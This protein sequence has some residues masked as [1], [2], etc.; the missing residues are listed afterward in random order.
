VP[1]WLWVKDGRTTP[2]VRL[3]GKVQRVMVLKRSALEEGEEDGNQ[4]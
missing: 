4:G 3:D 2:A 1:G